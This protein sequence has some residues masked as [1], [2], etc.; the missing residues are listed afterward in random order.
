MDA[1][2]FSRFAYPVALLLAG[3]LVI[4]LP[5]MRLWR[6][7]GIWAITGM[8]N[9]EPA[10]RTV[11]I[12]WLGCAVAVAVWSVA[13][14][15]L[16]PAALGVWTLPAWITWTGWVLAAL[17]LTVVMTAQVQM[18]SSWRIGIDA[19]STPLVTDG[20]FRFVRNPIYS[21]LCVFGIG[22]VLVSPSL[23][24]G[25]IEAASWVLI[26]IQARREEQHLRLLHGRPFEDWAGR[27]GRFVPWVGRWS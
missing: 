1:V 25:A 4:A 12:V 19:E 24:L 6:R 3:G 8:R 15:V 23:W 2:T 10:E 14:A 21:G 27:V 17:G 13:Y 26:E 20:L 18:G 22:L 5:A 7:T 11:Q 16:G 9:R